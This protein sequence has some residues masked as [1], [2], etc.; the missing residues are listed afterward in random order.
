MSARKSKPIK[1]GIV[2]LGR[3]GWDIHVARLRE[4]ERFAITAVSDLQDDRRQEA[5]A[6]SDCETF[7]DYKD[8][9]KNADC[10][11]V[12]IA[13]QSVD[14]APHSIAALKSG[15]HVVVEKPMAMTTAEA[16]RMIKAAQ[17][18]DK[19]LFVH[20]NYRYHPD[21][22]HIQ[23]VIKSGILGRVF[24]IRIRV[25]HFARRND[26]QT[27][28]KFG[29]G[30]LNNTCPH[31]IDAALLLLDSPVK[32][33]FTDLQLTT[34]VGDAD[35]HTKIVM[36]GENGR[37][38]DLE[39][40]TSCAFPEPKWTLLGTAGTLRSDGQTSELKYFDPKKAAPLKVDEAP[41]AGRKYGNGDVLP[42]Q[43]ETRPST[44]EVPT[45]FYD[46]VHSVIRN[47]K[48]MD[49]TPEH[50]REVIRIMETAHRENAP[51]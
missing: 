37:V 43:E 20:Q 49:I 10:E 38:I 30:N 51:L 40:S 6:D 31:F 21:V 14:H 25:L 29:G 44:A 12:V 34:D 35:D 50:V 2:G 22:H 23:E 17:A 27:L 45:D 42:W 11:L 9:L 26:W 39:V 18:A 19:K 1:V 8:L 48:K 47:R 46:N 24:E 3:A 15:R 41:P 32:R 16:T 5:R 33:L 28:Q 7:T 13:S 4:D 36:K